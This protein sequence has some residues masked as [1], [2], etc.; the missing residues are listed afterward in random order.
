MKGKSGD[1]Q[2]R[3]LGAKDLVIQDGSAY[4][5]FAVFG[6]K[7]H[8]DKLIG[9]REF[10]NLSNSYHLLADLIPPPD[11][12]VHLTA[13][14][15]VLLKRICSRGRDYERRIPAAY[16]EDLDA[17]YRGWT[18]AYSPCAILRIDTTATKLLTEAGVA[19][20]ARRVQDALACTAEP[21][22]DPR[23]GA[24]Q[25]YRDTTEA[26]SRRAALGT[27]HARDAR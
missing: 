16:L 18:G 24:R 9:Q 20:V 26:Q 25:R 13:P 11:L 6:R 3:A 1:Q 17:R 4:E 14:V 27:L 12:L 5:S 15:D 10:Q 19:S 2:R 23:R 21:S 8:D 7:F 22:V